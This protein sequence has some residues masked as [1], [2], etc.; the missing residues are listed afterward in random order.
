LPG[1]E[2]NIC[3]TATATRVVKVLKDAV[4]CGDAYGRHC[5]CDGLALVAMCL[6]YGS[7]VFVC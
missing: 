7:L 4:R 2:V 1:R 5:G 6:V 3:S